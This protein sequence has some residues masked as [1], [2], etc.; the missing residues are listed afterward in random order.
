MNWQIYALGGAFFASLTA[1][2]GKLGVRD[3]DSN[4]A[5][6][7]RTVVVL[8]F[9]W[10]VVAWQGKAR[11][12]ANVSQSTLAWLV[13]SGLMTGASWLLFFRALQMAPASRVAPLDK[14]SL[15]F[16]FVLAAV[17]L[18]EQI[19]IR[20]IAGVSLMVAGAVLLSR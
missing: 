3:I 9:A 11:D 19:G 13:V 20:E 2:T 12:L 6:A 16:T 5:T 15:A 10:S 7:I 4:L 18:R 1:I 14:L 17:F 8:V